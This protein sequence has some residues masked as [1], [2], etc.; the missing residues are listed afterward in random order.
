MHRKNLGLILISSLLL[1]LLFACSITDNSQGNNGGGSGNSSSQSSAPDLTPPNLTISNPTNDQEVGENFTFE[2]TVSDTGSGVK[3]VYVAIDDPSNFKKAKITGTSWS[4][5]I[6]SLSYGFHTNYVYAE[7]N[8]G[9]VTLTNEIKIIRTAVPSV[10]ISS[11]SEG[12]I[13]NHN[14]I[15]FT[16]NVSIENPFNIQK[17][18]YSIDDGA[19]YNTITYSGISWN[20]TISLSEGTNI[21]KIKATANNGKTTEVTR[22]VILD[23]IPP[24]VNITSPSTYEVSSTYTLAGTISDNILYKSIYVKLNNGTYKEINISGGSWSTN[25]TLLSYGKHTN[26]VYAKDMAGNTSTELMLPIEYMA[27]PQV[28]IITP[29]DNIFTNGNL[30]EVKASASI[31]SPYNIDKVEI[32]L[33]NSSFKEMSFASGNWLTNITLS[34][35]TNTIKIKA[36]ANNGKFTEVTRKVILDTTPPVVNITSHTNNQFV[37]TNYQLAGNFTEANIDK[38][39]ISVNNGVFTEA[40]ITGTSWNYSY[41]IISG[42]LQTNTVKAIDKA[43]NTT[44]KEIILTNSK[45]LAWTIMLLMNGDNDL[46]ANAMQDLNE[47]EAGLGG[48]EEKIHFIVLVDRHPSYD[49]SDGNWKGTRLYYMNYDSAGVNSSLISKRLS[50]MGLS[51]T[52]DSDELNLGDPNVLKSFVE[53]ST[54]YFPATNTMLILWDHGDGWRSKLQNPLQFLKINKR[55][56]N[57]TPTRDKKDKTEENIFSKISTKI[58]SIFNSQEDNSDPYPLKAISFDFTSQD[59][60]YNSE[61]RTALTGKNLTILGAD[62]CLMG[63]LETAYEWKNLAEYLIAS[64]ETE[65]GDGWEYNLW[66]PTFL[67]SSMT[68]QNLYQSIVDSYANRYST[69]QGATLAVYDLSKI[70]S[71]FNSFEA[72]VTNLYNDLLNPSHTIKYSEH[73]STVLNNVEAY[74]LPVSNGYHHVD[75]YELADKFDKGGGLAVKTALN[76]AVIYEWHHTGGDIVTGNPNSHGMSVY[77]FTWTKIGTNLYPDVKTDYSLSNFTLFNQSSIWDLYVDALVYQYDFPWLYHNVEMSGS[78]I[79]NK[80]NKYFQFYVS[81]PGTIKVTLNWSTSADFD[82]Y[83]YDSRTGNQLAYSDST[84]KPEIIN[85]SIL[86]PGWCILRARSYSGTGNFTIKV[87]GITATLK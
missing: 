70:N 63:M 45:R 72:Y 22:K 43:G 77:Y 51:I 36:T 31:D 59:Q 68:K 52:G 57:F 4:T 10:V 53:Y 20:L 75:V 30:I 11:P 44:T 2:G 56:I 48:A 25:I 8:A 26:Y 37:G 6:S 3:A 12:Y 82:L 87:E 17:L 55:E 14:T 61:V 9:N 1:S 73:L 24:V 74:T 40:N 42:T 67:S 66:L 46:E 33:N 21:I 15:E 18:E 35:G 78:L 29:Q 64:P 76:N 47:I 49:T 79:T 69:K 81:K 23:T 41:N 80:D 83:L 86:N 84:S 65:D 34:E 54:L 62:A 58:S 71:L 38:I 60:L 7:D 13:T 28:N 32:S 50:G 85:T 16:G 27:I 19:N 39:L 5:N